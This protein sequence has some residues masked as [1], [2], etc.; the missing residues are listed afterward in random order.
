MSPEAASRAY[1]L[2]NRILQ[3]CRALERAIPEQ[4]ERRRL[5]LDEL[6]A[7]VAAAQDTLIEQ[8]PRAGIAAATACS[9]CERT[10]EDG[11]KLLAGP[12][13]YICDE[14]IRL[15]SDIIV[16]EPELREP[17]P[18]TP[19]KPALPVLGGSD[20]ELDEPSSVRRSIPPTGRK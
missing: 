12:G 9:F 14:C 8:H 10:Q 1:D 15:C 18:K 17:S 20:D 3:I 19:P 13:V 6:A 16:E 4:D 11:A 7:T 2:L 5:Q